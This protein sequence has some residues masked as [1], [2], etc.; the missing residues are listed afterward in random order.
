MTVS[1][2]QVMLLMEQQQRQFEAESEK[3]FQKYQQYTAAFKTAVQE[4]I[5]SD[6]NQFPTKPEDDKV[7]AQQEAN[8]SV[9][10]YQ[11][12]IPVLKSEQFADKIDLAPS[13]RDNSEWQFTVVPECWG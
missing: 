9:A 1:F 13:F 5:K 7:S 6:G 11:D 8:Q 4:I 2:E 10:K 12:K 3:I